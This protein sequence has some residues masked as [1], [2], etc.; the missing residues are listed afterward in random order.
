MDALLHKNRVVCGCVVAMIALGGWVATAAVTV[1]EHVN[2]IPMDSERVLVDQTVIVSGGLIYWIG[3][4]TQARIPS[5]ANVIHCNR[6]FYLM[7]GLADMHTHA[8]NLEDLRLYLANGVTTTLNMGNASRTFVVETRKQIEEGKIL[9]PHVFA[10]FLID[11]SP[12][13][14]LYWVHDEEDARATV[15]RAREDGYEFIKVYNNL[16]AP[17]FSA[18]ADESKKQH[19]AV[20]GHGVRSVGLQKSFEQGQVMV[21]HGEEYLYTYFA[22]AA[23]NERGSMI[24]GAV[25]FTRNAGAYVTPNLS[26]YEAIPLQW[27]N[28]AQVRAFLKSPDVRYLRPAIRERWADSD[29]ARRPGTLDDNLQFLREFTGALSKAGVPLLLGTDSPN[30]PGMAPGFSIHDDL[31]N[32]IEA[33]LTP[34]EALLAGTRVAGEFIR[35]TVPGADRFGV[36]AVGSR[37]DLILT[38]L[39]PLLDVRNVENPVGVMVHGRWLAREEIRKMLNEAGLRYQSGMK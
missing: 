17:E 7:P 20:I 4:A 19:L 30:I 12:E 29:Y 6:Q 38:R 39:N 9:G 22:R 26:T 18:I 15:R 34:Y 24:A 1:F 36:V 14:G 3:P 37:A 2:V 32:M 28:P 33:G 31:R 5:S 8:E 13:L 23:K 21:A 25:E 35:K 10:G 11:G 27:G 16:T